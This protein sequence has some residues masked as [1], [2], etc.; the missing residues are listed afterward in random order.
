VRSLL[1]GVATALR[2]DAPMPLVRTAGGG[3]GGLIAQLFGNNRRNVEAQLKA[4]GA[5]GTLFGIVNRTS[6]ATSLV[7]WHL[8]RKRVDGRKSYGPQEDNR[9]EVTKHLAL[10]IWNKPNDFT[11]RQ[12]LVEGGQQ[13]I[14]LTGEGW[15]VISYLDQ[16]HKIPGEL[17]GP[18]RPDKM[19]PVEHPT[20]FISGYVYTGPNGEKVPLDI[21]EVMF[22]RMPNPLDLYRGMGP[23]QA[24]LTD[25]DATKYS[26]EWNRNF[27]LN[28]AEP[29]GLIEV[30]A[31]LD[32][33]EFQDMRRRWNEQHKGV[34]KAHRVA[35]L[36]HGKW[37]DRAFSQRDMQFA[38]LRTVSRDTILEA[39][40]FPKSMLGITEDVNRANAVTGKAMFAEDLTIPRLERW[41]LALNNDFLPRFGATG[42]GLEFDYDSPV[43]EFAEE[44][45]AR[46]TARTTAYK[47][48]IDA[49][50]DPDDAA[51]VC[52]LP[53]MGN[54][55]RPQITIAPPPPPGTEPPAPPDSTPPPA[56]EAQA[57]RLEIVVSQAMAV[58]TGSVKLPVLRAAADSPAASVD[59]APV[60]KTLDKRLTQL[61]K[62]WSDVQ[63][64]QIDSLVDQVQSIVAEDNLPGLPDMTVPTDDA[65][66]ALEA[67]MVAIGAE[68][69]DQV[70]DEADEQ[71]VEIQPAHPAHATLSTGAAVIVG[72]LARNLVTSAATEALRQ[73]GRGSEAAAVAEAVRSHLESLTDAQPR[74]QLGAGLHR[75]QHAGRVSTFAAAERTADSDVTYYASEVNDSNTCGPCAVEDGKTLGHKVTD[76]EDDYPTGGYVE[77][78][79]RLRCRGHI[80]AVWT[81]GDQA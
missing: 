77:C 71:D 63:A 73:A 54:T 60:A 51:E 78:D 62:D 52:E 35:I 4:M 25:L 56:P 59:L 33:T 39:F 76:A 36:E 9:Q 24:V 28:S 2:N 65:H 13:H 38:Q 21:D 26:A 57:H 7:D 32:D 81:I 37:V 75:A 14:D 67:A 31:T 69:A 43:P 47:T 41:K 42:K 17:W 58:D 11:T 16:A 53:A 19:A 10:D 22:I 49:G 72:L 6:T 20:K 64:G 29:G 23:V 12:E 40:G 46:L 66:A 1:G 44:D 50:V 55:P 48:L 80:V 15:M 45:N 8:Y 79:G 34:G 74:L 27:F 68:A 70:V 3:G 5:V 30:D 61:L 18:I